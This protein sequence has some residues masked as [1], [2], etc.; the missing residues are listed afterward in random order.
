MKEKKPMGTLFTTN[1]A[2][3][4]KITF[5]EETEMWQITRAGKEL[6]GGV[7]VK[8][9]APSPKLFNMF[10]ENWKGNPPHTWWNEYEK[11]FQEEL[12]TEEKL[13][14]LRELYKKLL[15]GRNIV[16]VCFCRDHQYCHRKLVADFFAK[17][18]V[19]VQE[20]NPI[21]N[22]QLFLF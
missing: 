19:E 13:V 15:Q 14:V 16:L 22:E 5:T 18:S 2:G 10:V 4:R 9:L 7:I 11:A 17:Y 21:E 8:E 20:L 1:P 3:L 12:K 6:P